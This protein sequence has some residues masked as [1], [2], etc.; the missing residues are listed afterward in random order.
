MLKRM[1][2]ARALARRRLERDARLYFRACERKPGRLIDTTFFK[3]GL[4]A[5][6]KVRAGMQNEKR[7]PELIGPHQLLG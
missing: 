4:F 7:Q 2:K 6:A 1:T 5:R 3:S